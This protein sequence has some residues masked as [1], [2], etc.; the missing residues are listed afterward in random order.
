MDTVSSHRPAH[1]QSYEPCSPA[2]GYTNASSRLDP[3]ASR[4]YR[5]TLRTNAI[6]GTPASWSRICYQAMQFYS[7]VTEFILLIALSIYNQEVQ[8]RAGAGI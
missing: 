3:E 4:A 5:P 6:A 1:L 7:V 2:Q 8:R